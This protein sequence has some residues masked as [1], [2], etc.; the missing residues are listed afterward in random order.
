MPVI[1]PPCPPVRPEAQ[2]PEFGQSASVSRGWRS[3]RRSTESV[4][5]HQI[6]RARL[7]AVLLLIFGILTNNGSVTTVLCG[8]L[9]PVQRDILGDDAAARHGT[10]VWAAEPAVAIVEADEPAG[11]VAA[12]Q[13]APAAEA[14]VAAPLPV[15]PPA[16]PAAG[17]QAPS[18]ANAVVSPSSEYPSLALINGDYLPGR[19]LAIDQA[20]RLLFQHPAFAGP[21]EFPATAWTSIRWSSPPE[22][23]QADSLYSCELA[24]RDYL[25]GKLLGIDAETVQ[26]SNPIF[27][28]LA[29]RREFVE[30]L[31]PINSS[32]AMKY[33]GPRNLAEWSVRGGTAA[34]WSF[35]SL[36]LCGR[37]P[38]SSASLDL[39]L[40]PLATIELEL[41]WSD[42][43]RF[44]VWLAVDPDKQSQIGGFRLEVIDGQ[45]VLIRELALQSELVPL[46]SLADVAN[47][48]LRLRIFVNQTAGQA[49]VTQA[50]GRVL[51]ELQLLD[52]P[53][54]KPL[55]GLPGGNVA[56]VMRFAGAARG[57]QPE[58]A[59]ATDPNAPPKSGI[60]IVNHGAETRLR[61]LRVTGWSGARPAATVE[62]PVRI[63]QASGE[64]LPAT[65][66]QL[67]PESNTLVASTGA[68][69][70]TSLEL[71]AIAGISFE[72]RS[73]T[74]SDAV[75][76]DLRD[77]Q[78]LQGQLVGLEND[79]V[80]V[81]SE[82]LANPIRI[83]VHKLSG[84]TTQRAAGE[85][86]SESVAAGRQGRLEL[87]VTR[88]QGVM[89][90]APKLA[91]STP[92]PANADTTSTT[93]LSDGTTA[94]S[95][96]AAPFG[97]QPSGSLRSAAFRVDA[98]GRVSYSEPKPSVDPAASV[99]ST[100]ADGTVV[101]LAVQ[102]FGA[103]LDPK[104]GTRR[105]QPKNAAVAEQS[106]I[107][108][109]GGDSIE[110]RVVSID[111]TGVL[112]DSPVVGRQLVPHNEIKLAELGRLA[113]EI[114]I[115]RGRREKVLTL[116]RMMK[117][118][119][120]QH[121]LRSIT[122]D[123]LR[124]TVRRLTDTDVEIEVRLDVRTIPRSKVSRILW[125]HPTPSVGL[126]NS[127]PAA[128][129][130]APQPPSASPDSS[131]GQPSPTTG[132][133]VQGVSRQ[134]KRLTLVPHELSDGVLVGHHPVMGPA[135]LDLASV[136]QLVIG[137][138][139]EEQS[140]VLA[141]QAW[142]LTPAREPSFMTEGDEGS[143]SESAG[144]Q[145]RLV[146]RPAPDFELDTAA[147][148]K[149]Q[150]SKEK[151]KIVVLDFW[152]SW[153]GPCLQAMPRIH[154]AVESFGRDDVQLLGVNLEEG[155]D[156]ISL[157]LDRLD[158]DLQVALDR[159]GRVAEKYGAVA[160]PQTVVIDREGIVRRV[161]VGGS[162]QLEDELRT[163]IQ[164]LLGPQ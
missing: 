78:R 17:A 109:R 114:K 162:A 77:G 101:N 104:A 32:E 133:R 66:I 116:P 20:G 55:A 145:S 117:D 29:V 123:V 21:F 8:L 11:I 161:F 128:E 148:G 86:T 48:E 93:F 156:R 138:A 144:T 120:P 121:L 85:L 91:S 125:L 119:P 79:F 149:Y 60:V 40:E 46:L 153:C 124:G 142:K 56:A 42:E 75:Q 59:T 23:L 103:L 164:S 147:G 52:D 163:A 141:Y 92:G 9:G 118:H 154:R 1:S 28:R 65:D 71:S 137:Q 134:G 39:K 115:G 90:A 87:P 76:L 22:S 62:A 12:A 146:G 18:A 36:Q 88:L 51:G 64:F 80:I 81:N 58:A 33:L 47:R 6:S 26:L 151:G 111:E 72:T 49:I 113:G 97:W 127:D 57:E 74:G 67:A 30:R 53:Q 158:L 41:S 69:R 50:D 44:E 102:A 63:Q 94:S 152:A 132:L 95:V 107:H 5:I 84:I 15:A 110:C 99:S 68:D 54:A 14:P 3:H 122:G 35:E 45:L 82:L 139:I 150:L 37:T 98:S 7:S 96:L 16:A 131:A 31:Q 112:I 155:T 2:R 4:S 10:T 160:I 140:S 157:T 129:S 83:P 13:A 38:G 89:T 126:A 19:L 73:R 25:V 100:P 61:R 136:D 143:P 159:N 70:T 34:S 27:G 130:G 24:G 105:K 43:P 108:L 135:R 106:M